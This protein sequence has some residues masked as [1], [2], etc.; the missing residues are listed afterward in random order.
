MKL[1]TL[2][3]LN[4]GLWAV[5]GVCIMSMMFHIDNMIALCSSMALA[6]ACFVGKEI[7]FGMI[8]NHYETQPEKES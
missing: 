1:K 2:L 5:I 4:E 6:I 7:L 3:Y 8:S